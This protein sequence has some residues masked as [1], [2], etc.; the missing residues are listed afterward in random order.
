MTRLT[1][2]SEAREELLADLMFSVTLNLDALEAGRIE[3]G[4]QAATLVPRSARVLADLR[5]VPGV[6]AERVVALIR[7]HL[8][9][10]GFDHVAVTLR[11]A[12]PASR[13]APDAPVVQAMIGACRVKA[14]ELQV[15]PIHAGAAPMHRFSEVI[16]IPYAFGD[17]GHGGGSARAGRIHHGRRRR[18]LHAR[19]R[20]LPGPLR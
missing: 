4:G 16:G 13:S 9:R 8:D 15:F 5:V 12:Y 6:S 19:L 7:A 3:A 1:R 10:R 17:V 20:P 18:A 11:S 2:G 14:P